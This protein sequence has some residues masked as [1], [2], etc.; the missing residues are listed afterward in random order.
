MA[1]QHLQ[2]RASQEAQQALN[3]LQSEWGYEDRTECLDASIICW[4][5]ALSA[6]AE[7][8]A[9]RFSLSEW[10]MMADVCNGTRAVWAYGHTGSRPGMLLAA[11]VEDGHRLNGTGYRWLSDSELTAQTRSEVDQKV[12]DLTGRLHALEYVEALAVIRAICWFWQNTEINC[13]EDAWWEQSFRRRYIKE[14]KEES[15]N[16]SAD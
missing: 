3:T 10:N 13:L 7:S 1:K 16:A 14:R 11:E 2:F 5:Y 9:E 8:V 6:A 12:H 15:S 4:E